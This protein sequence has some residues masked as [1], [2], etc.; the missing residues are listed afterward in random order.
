NNTKKTLQVLGFEDITIG[1]N[2]KNNQSTTVV[3][4]TTNGTKPFSLDE[5]I[6]KLPAQKDK[7][8]QNNYKTDF[9]IILGSD[10]LDSYTYTEISQEELE[11]E[12]AKNI[13]K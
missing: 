6:K 1:K 12:N 2:T 13:D 8:P 10:M 4:D 5:L 11:Q 9:I 3:I 7:T